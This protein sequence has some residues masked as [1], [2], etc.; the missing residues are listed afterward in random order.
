MSPAYGDP[1]KYQRQSLGRL[2]NGWGRHI[3]ARRIPEGT[4]RLAFLCRKCRVLV[5]YT[6]DRSEFQKRNH[7]IAEPFLSH[8]LCP[9]CF[10]QD[11]P[12]F[13][14]TI[15]EMWL[16]DVKKEGWNIVAHLAAKRTCTLC[17]GSGSEKKGYVCS[18]CDGRKQEII[19]WI[20]LT[21]DHKEDFYKRFEKDLKPWANYWGD[22]EEAK[23]RF[24]WAEWYEALVEALR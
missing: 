20:D 22:T 6:D 11:F 12:K 16:R 19:R 17:K 1:S 15:Q 21:E 10:T 5:S 13:S 8:K 2:L 24:L 14:A 7:P 9:R 23:G 18:L 3:A 4:G